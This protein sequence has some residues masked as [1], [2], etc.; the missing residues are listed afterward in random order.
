MPDGSAGTELNHAHDP[1]RFLKGGGR[2][3]VNFAITNRCNARCRFCSFPQ[4]KEER[5]VSL[6]EGL[7]A[8]DF[9]AGINT[10]VL[11]LTGGEPLMSP[12]LPAIAR[13]ARE[14]G[15]IVYT[16]TNGILLSPEMARKLRQCGLNAVWISF[17]S[18][19][20]ATF[21]RNRGVKGLHRKISHGLSYLKDEGVN[22]FAIC[23]INRSIENWDGLVDRLVELGFDKVKFDYPIGFRLDSTYRGWSESSLLKFSGDEMEEAVEAI[24]RIRKEGRIKVI[25]PT[26][27][28]RGAVEF[29]HGRPSPFPCCAGDNVLYLDWNLDLYRCPARGDLLGRVGGEAQLGRVDCDRC[30]YQGVRDLDPFYHFLSRMDLIS[31][32]LTGHGIKGK[33]GPVG[34]NE[35]VRLYRG[36]Q[37]IQEFRE[38]GII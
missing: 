3:M 7:R 29:Y 17:E 30:Y 4:E 15:M 8:V 20:F 27:G 28:L 31:S 18:S 35:L 10:G 14:M 9:L 32:G 2:R 6:E 26:A 33:L 34:R 25:N 37:T 1:V 5:E 12:H 36:F 38:C 23:L 21:N 19:S 11:S 16:G 22:T 13:R 24:L